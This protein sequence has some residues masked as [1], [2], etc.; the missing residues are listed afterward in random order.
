MAY[1]GVVPSATTLADLWNSTRKY[2]PFPKPTTLL[3]LHHFEIC[4]YW[5]TK[6]ARYSTGGTRV[7]FEVSYR[8]NGSAEWVAP[9]AVRTPTLSDTTVRMSVPFVGLSGYYAVTDVE[10]RQN[11]GPAKM[12]N[13]LDQKRRAAMLDI[14]KELESRAWEAPEDASDD[15]HLWGVPYHVVPIQSGQ[16]AGFNGA[17]PYYKDGTQAS[18]YQGIDVSQ[19]KYARIRNYNDRWTNDEGK[20]TE[21]DINRLAKMF[22]ML[23]WKPP[24]QMADLEKPTYARFRIYTNMN[25]IQGLR[26]YV[27][28]ANSQLGKDPAAFGVR[29]QDGWPILFGYPVIWIEKLD[30]DSTNP[31][32]MLNL[33]ELVPIFDRNAHFAESDAMNDVSQHDVWVTYI[34]TRLNLACR[35]RRKLGVI[36]YVAE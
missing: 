26:E 3:P 21:E 35:D 11:A 4:D 36:S 15:T 2:R 28:S 13:L 19:A 32:Y 27:R 20:I 17:L 23:Q 31:L 33:D 10:L 34:D 6:A 1:T 25:I 9:G 12:W 24:R 22:M 8:E 29:L 14:M 18:T 5:L 16:T 30:E 7:E